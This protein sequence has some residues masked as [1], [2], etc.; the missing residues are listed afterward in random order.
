MQMSYEV[1][2][3][4]M[5]TASCLIYLFASA[6]QYLLFVLSAL[7]GGEKFVL[8]TTTSRQIATQYSTRQQMQ[9]NY[10]QE[11]SGDSNCT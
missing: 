8:V 10:I 6:C 5:G 4:G 2:L 11:L 9:H 7:E 1:L 3:L